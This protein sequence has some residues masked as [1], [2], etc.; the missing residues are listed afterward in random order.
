MKKNEWLKM[1][2]NSFVEGT[3]IATIAIIIVKLIGMLYIIPFYATVGSQGSALY[4]YA[5]N[6]YNLFLEISSAGLPIAISKIINEYNTLGLIEA[7][8]RAYKIGTK[9]ITIISFVSFILLFVFA[10][11]IGVLILGDLQ[12]GNT[13]GDV[14]FVIRCISFAILVIPF[15]SITKGYLQ[16][17]NYIAPSSM[18]LIIEQVVRIFVILIGSYV[19]L[20]VLDLGIKNSVG[21]AVFGAFIGGL[22]A[23]V[24][25]FVKMKK[26]KE[27]LNLYEDRKI[28]KITSKEILR[29]IISYAIPF[30]IINITASIY[31]FTN[32][33]LILRTLSYLGYEA[34]D[35]EF[36][37]NA[38]T[39]LG[40][41]LNM[42]VGALASGLTVSLIPNIVSSFVKKDFMDIKSKVNRAFQIILIIS[43][44][45]T[46]ALSILAVPAWTS[47]Y[48]PSHYGPII[49][50]LSIFTVLFSN[51]YMV[52]GSTLQGLNKFKTVYLSTILGF[53]INALLD[54]PLMLLFDKINIYPFYGALLST[55]IGYTISIAIALRVLKKDHNIDVK[56]TLKV[57][58]KL[59]LPTIAM[60]AV[61]IVLK[62]LIPYNS[63][64]RVSSIL[65]I[66]M[67]ALIGGFVYLFITYKQ[68]LLDKI[69][70]KEIINKIIKKL[71]F[72][73]ISYKN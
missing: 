13:I 3:L 31:S 25:V 1:K 33:V 2:K 50:K 63:S 48:G 10:R 54:V 36:I 57:S 56:D 71:T 40:A 58:L 32:M 15:L 6:I 14:A 21:V 69:F 68:G 4:G 28:D 47:F 39:T 61:L 51:L 30:I 8:V 16:G 70:G 42:I 18:S 27:K 19:T 62:L 64:N 29:K 5:Y 49:F 46:V 52:S 65:F 59:I 45:A 73:K 60:A 22:A 53:L 38:I 7:K 67:N 72:G 55:A 43:L 26:N 23:C 20:K 37:T 66:L 24:Y 41:K 12:G 34:I 9:L 11:E 35:A 17:H 44:P